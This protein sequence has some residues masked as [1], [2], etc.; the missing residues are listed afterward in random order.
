MNTDRERSARITSRKTLH[1]GFARLDLLHIS[2]RSPAGSA[3]IEREVHSHGHVAA[4]LPVDPGRGTGV[5]VRQFRTAPFLADED[6]WIPEIPAG[7]L[8]EESP[9]ACAEREAG[10]ETGLEIREVEPLGATWSSPGALFERVHLFWGRYE[11][12]PPAA[13]AGLDEEAELIEVS[14]MP[15]AEIRRMCIDGRIEDAKT[16]IAVLRLAAL[17]PDL[18]G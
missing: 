4:L 1:E 13:H 7:L 9:A 14:E 10:E 5:L 11:G 16:V 15:L 2:V 18:F 12:P 17:R 6:A 3:E 8:D